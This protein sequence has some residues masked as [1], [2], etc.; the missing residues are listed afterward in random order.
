MA[1]WVRTTPS[2]VVMTQLFRITHVSNLPHILDHGLYAPSSGSLDDNFTS[3]GYPSLI[4]LRRNREV[5]LPPGGK[6][7]DYIPFYFWYRSPML[8]VIHR[9]NDPEVIRTPQEEIIYLISSV[10]KIIECS[11][12]FFFTDRHAQLDYARFFNKKS[13]LNS[14]NWELIKS[15]NWGRYQGTDSKEIKQ[16]EFLVHL[17]LP[18]EGIIGIAVMN[19]SVEKSV[20]KMLMNSN[21]E[22]EVKVKPNFYF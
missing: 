12:K 8:Y 6:L 15:E 4:H 17:Y 10:E 16:S 11:L 5:P 3:I 13:D 2:L 19:Q 7:A 22:I 18:I 14:L 9:A 20:R 1:V 21:R